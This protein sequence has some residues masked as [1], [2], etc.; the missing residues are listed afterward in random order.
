MTREIEKLYSIAKKE[1]KLTRK[2][3]QKYFKEYVFE[4]GLGAKGV[5][6]DAYIG[7]QITNQ[8]DRDLIRYM[9]EKEIFVKEKDK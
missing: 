1:K 6:D 4:N 3:F 2:E 5:D 7:N 8:R 9:V